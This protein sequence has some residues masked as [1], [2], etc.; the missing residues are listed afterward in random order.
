MTPVRL[1]YFALV[2]E[3]VGLDSEIRELP[4][5]LETVGDC[6]SWLTAQGDNYAAAF[7]DPSRLRFALDQ[8]MA[9]ADSLLKGAGELAIFPP[10]TGG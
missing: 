7:A 4:E 10:V 3:A 9:R 1:V 8:Q 6:L 2:R 5:A